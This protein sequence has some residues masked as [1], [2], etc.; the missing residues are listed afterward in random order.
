MRCLVEGVSEAAG[1]G[2][3]NKRRARWT[4]NGQEGK[5]TGKNE[6]RRR[7]R[8]SCYILERVDLG[9]SKVPSIRPFIAKQDFL[10]IHLLQMHFTNRYIFLGCQFVFFSFPLFL[11]L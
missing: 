4:R 5:G 3:G 11:L 7:G 6:G 10:F 1:K 8:G 9:R 2:N